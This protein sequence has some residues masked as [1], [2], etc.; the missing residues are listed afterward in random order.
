V[1]WQFEA[2][3]TIEHCVHIKNV[4]YKYCSEVK[5]PLLLNHSEHKVVQD[6][7]PS[8]QEIMEVFGGA[9]KI[10][11]SSVIM[12]FLLSIPSILKKR[13]SYQQHMVDSSLECQKLLP[14]ER[15]KIDE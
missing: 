14:F 11:N 10:E 1:I 9:S 2:N 13:R 15:M 4:S 8:M 5:F 7:A 6:P 12:Y 3:C